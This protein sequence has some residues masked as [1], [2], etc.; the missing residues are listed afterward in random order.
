MSLVLLNSNGQS[1]NHFQNHFKQPL[2][3][4]PNSQVCCIKFMYKETAI[5]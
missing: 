3:I 5:F 2:I 4:E 1:A